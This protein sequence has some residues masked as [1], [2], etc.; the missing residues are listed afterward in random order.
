MVP[1][2]SFGMVSNYCKCSVFC[3]NID[4]MSNCLATIHTMTNQ[5]S[6]AVVCVIIEA[7]VV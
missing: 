2:I 4:S 1:P 6:T 7:A 3:N 5:S